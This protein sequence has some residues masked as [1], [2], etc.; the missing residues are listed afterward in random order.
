V[1]DIVGYF[2]NP[3]STPVECVNGPLTVFVI[4]PGAN[5]VISPASACPAG[6]GEAGVN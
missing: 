2:D 1:V 6:Y 3:R 4:A 5:N